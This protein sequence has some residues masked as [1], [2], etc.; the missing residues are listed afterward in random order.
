M[1]GLLFLLTL[2]Q[3]MFILDYKLIIYFEDFY[4]EYL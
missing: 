1:L 4:I 2:I 3:N